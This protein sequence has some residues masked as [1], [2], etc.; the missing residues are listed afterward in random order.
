[1]AAV[2]MIAPP[3][4]PMTGMTTLTGSRSGLAYKLGQEIGAGGNGVVYTVSRRPELVAKIQKSPLTRHDVDK[5][6]VL[7]RGATPELLSVADRKSTRL[8]SS[9]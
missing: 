3:R 1:M 6:E 4:T 7:V 8:N 9:H 5:L 2:A